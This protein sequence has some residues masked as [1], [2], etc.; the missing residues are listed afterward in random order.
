MTEVT[1]KDRT[2]AKNLIDCAAFSRAPIQT[3]AEYLVSIRERD[4][5]EVAELRSAC[6]TLLAEWDS[7]DGPERFVD[8]DFP[9]FS[10]AGRMVNTEHVARIRA[11]LGG[12]A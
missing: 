9:H 6:N 4:L 1:D 3:I 10:P 12:N 2:D 11:I 5:K 7:F 8:G